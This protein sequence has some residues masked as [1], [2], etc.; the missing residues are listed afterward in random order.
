M[1][2]NGKRF[3][4]ALLTLALAMGAMA[5]DTVTYR[6][7]RLVVSG[8]GDSVS[9]VGGVPSAD[10]SIY[11]PSHLM[12]Y[13]S[14][15]PVAEVGPQAFR[16]ERGLAH[17]YIDTINRT[18]MGAFWSC[19]NLRSVVTKDIKVI[20]EHT[21]KSCN[22]LR[23]WSLLCPPP[24]MKNN[25][26]VTVGVPIEVDIPCEYKDLYLEAD[27]WNVARF[28]SYP[29]CDTTGDNPGGDTTGDDPDTTA[30]GLSSP[31]AAFGVP[32]PNPTSGLLHLP[33][34]AATAMLVATDGRCLWRGKDVD[35][36]DL[37]QL[38]AGLYMLRIDGAA[39][40]VVRR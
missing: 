30:V 37:S 40:K 32:Y 28:F 21:F 27:I 14:R 16:D 2:M 38:P 26:V 17:L 23:S 1:L 19:T 4:M 9:I 39:Y 7:C 18:R 5:Q 10:S 20:G 6:D 24:I 25:T 12:F 11:I 29:D 22:Y 13:G 34:R 33:Q 31:S 3:F 36:V 15:L 8:N 35:A